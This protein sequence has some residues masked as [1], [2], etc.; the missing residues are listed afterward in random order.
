MCNLHRKELRSRLEQESLLYGRFFVFFCFFFVFFFVF[1][2]F[3]FCF[4][5]VSFY[6][7]SMGIEVLLIQNKLKGDLINKKSKSINKKKE[8]EK[9]K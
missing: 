9:E 7:K 5:L 4:F 2:W 8:K 3:L 6:L 1:F